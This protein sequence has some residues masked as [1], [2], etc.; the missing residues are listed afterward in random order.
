MRALVA[1]ALFGT[2]LSGPPQ[3]FRS[4]VDA[5]RVDVLVSDGRLPVGGLTSADFELRDNGVKQAIDD[6]QIGEVPFSMMLALDASGSMEGS[7]LGHLRDGARAALDALRP[8]DRAAL[9][10]F[11][12]VI[13]PPTPW[14]ADR[15]DL[16]SAIAALK[17]HGSTSLF[18]AT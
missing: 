6:L 7:P 8:D 16:T 10:A 5:V 13:M 4:A 9:I 2:V 17:A 15:R 3:V 14:T 1:G 11:N 12:H 18:D